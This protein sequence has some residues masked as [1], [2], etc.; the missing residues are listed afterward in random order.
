[1]NGKLTD[2]MIDKFQ[3]YYGIALR[4][5]LDSVVSMRKAIFASFLHVAS[6]EQ[7]N[8]HDHCPG[9][10]TSWCQYNRDKAMNTKLYKPGK[11]LSTEIVAHVKRIYVE[12]TN[13]ELLKKCLHGTTQNRNESFN[14]MIWERIPKV[15]YVS[16]NLFR[17]GVHDA[18]AHFNIGWKASVLVYEKLGI[19]PGR[20]CSWGTSTLNRRRL[21]N[22]S[23]KDKPEV[24]KRRKIIRAKGKSK[25][26]KINKKEGVLYEAGAF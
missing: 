14:N 9:G 23:Y 3:N 11:G 1:M 5:N 24:K 8:W 17:L 21:Y 22:A 25:G 26:D 18:V 2:K 15:T 4:S 19:I 16:L 12:L 7:N 20:Y 6:S 13:E 10:S